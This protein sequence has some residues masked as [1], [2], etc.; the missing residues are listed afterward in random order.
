[1]DSG[2]RSSKPN[3]A[4]KKGVKV[5]LTKLVNWLPLVLWASGWLMFGFGFLSDT[6]VVVKFALLSIAR[7]LP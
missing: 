5:M 4:W 3:F 6:P 1:M 2:A 7:V